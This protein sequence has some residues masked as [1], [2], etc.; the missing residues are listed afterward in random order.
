MT[1]SATTRE[2]VA[3]GLDTAPALEG[4]EQLT[5]ARSAL[6]PVRAVA[7]RSR[8]PSGRGDGEGA[9]VRRPRRE[10]QRGAGGVHRLVPAAEQ[11]GRQAVARTVG[12]RR[13]LL[14]EPPRLAVDASAA[15]VV[16]Q[17]APAARRRDRPARSKR[18]S[19]TGSFD[20]GDVDATRA[21]RSSPRR[22][23]TQPSRMLTLYPRADGA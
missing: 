19:R 11:P 15:R 12:P 18:S 13:R 5:A 8:L 17:A 23:S 21:R 7:R 22:S 3:C 9:G 10:R 16:R 6:G 1:T 2:Y 4:A 20:D 14:S